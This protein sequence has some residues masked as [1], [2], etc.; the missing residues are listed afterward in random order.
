[1]KAALLLIL[2]AACGDPQSKVDASV[3]VID[4]PKPVDAPKP[5][6]AAVDA[7][8]PDASNMQIVATC[9]KAC[10]ALSVCFMEPVEPDCQMGCEE[11]LADC[12]VQQVMTIDACT[13]Q[14][15]GDI[16]NNMSPLLNCII[17]VP[18]IDPATGGGS[19]FI[20]LRK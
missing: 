17:A 12:S 9:T 10:M 20:D 14:A 4:S 19:S 16:M 2:L 18:C 8:G 1:M 7:P 6:D 3:Q 15:C 5:I 11:D 13:T